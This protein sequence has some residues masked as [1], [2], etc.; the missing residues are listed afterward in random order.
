[1]FYVLA[2]NNPDDKPSFFIV[3]IDSYRFALGDFNITGTFE[4]SPNTVVFWLIFFIGTI[5]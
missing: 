4:S 2:M 5:V 3:A 1:M